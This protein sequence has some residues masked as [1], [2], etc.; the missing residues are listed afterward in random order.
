LTNRDWALLGIRLIALWKGVELLIYLAD[1]PFSSPIATRSIVYLLTKAVV[2]AALWTRAKWIASKAFPEADASGGR[3][4]E[5][6][7]SRH[8]LAAALTVLG[9]YLAAE[10]VVSL[11]GDLFVVVA[12]RRSSPSVLGYGG[13]DDWGLRLMAQSKA[14]AVAEAA[15]F[16]IGLVL[17][18]YSRRIGTAVASVGRD[19]DAAE[20]SAGEEDAEE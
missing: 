16:V 14:D 1:L 19:E 4:M 11:A 20:S 7:E 5:A 13:A 17:T 2:V 12:I 15:R 10:A 18:L 8:L 6:P 3:R 9:V